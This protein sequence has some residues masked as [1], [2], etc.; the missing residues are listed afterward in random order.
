M[1]EEISVSRTAA[2][3][4]TSE[5]AQAVRRIAEAPAEERV[6][7]IGEY[8]QAQIAG[9]LGLATSEL[10]LDQPLDTVGLDS[11]MASQ[12]KNRV[13]SV[14]GAQLPIVKFLEGPSINEFAAQLAEQVSTASLADQGE[15]KDRTAMPWRPVVPA[16]DHRYAPFPL[17]DLQQAYWVGRSGLIEL[18]VPA[19]AYLEF[20]IEEVDLER[21]TSAV[22]RVIDRHDMLRMI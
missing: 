15:P 4:P 11:L 7:L 6:Q 13:E 1:S 8:L 21:L 19:S 3:D 18:S 10:D 5:E 20:E 2:I 16:P 17:T 12:L 9:V 22:R 14:L